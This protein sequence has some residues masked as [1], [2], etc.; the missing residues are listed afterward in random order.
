M[1]EEDTLDPVT[2]EALEKFVAGYRAGMIAAYKNA[3]RHLFLAA[4]EAPVPD[5]FRPGLRIFAKY[6]NKA[7]REL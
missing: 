2:Q 3:A 4:R 6:F 1:D 5:E 7:A